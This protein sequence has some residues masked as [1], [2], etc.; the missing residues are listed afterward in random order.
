MVVYADPTLRP[1]L[2]RIGQRFTERTGASV[3]VFS[4]APRQHVELLAHGTQCDVLITLPAFLDEAAF[5]GL[6]SR[7]VVPLWRGRLVFAGTSDA[8]AEPFDH[9]R[10]LARLG[11]HALAVPDTVPGS[12]IDG[13]G[14]LVNLAVYDAVRAHLLGARD[15]GEAADLVLDGSAALALTQASDAAARDG[16]HVA[17]T[18]PDTIHAPIEF[19]AVLT[20]SAWSRN[21]NR[22]L[23]HLQG[24]DSR[25]AARAGGLEIFT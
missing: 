14:A 18:I 21:Q 13:A 19:G 6:V 11:G 22:F 10:F 23:A 24:E 2:L 9:D 17:Y 5:R 3:H 25:A 12:T 4:A 7:D 20:R 1:V 8:A 15:S 16:L